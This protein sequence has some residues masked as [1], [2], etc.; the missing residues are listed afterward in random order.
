MRKKWEIISAV[1]I[2][3]IV[4]GSYIYY[5]SLFHPGDLVYRKSD[6]AVGTI[7]GIKVFDSVYLVKFDKVYSEESFSNIGPISDYKLIFNGSNINND[8]ENLENYFPGYASGFTS[9][10]VIGES[11]VK[12][13]S[14]QN[15]LNNLI[16]VNGKS[17]MVNYV[18]SAWSNCKLDLGLTGIINGSSSGGVRYKICSDKNKCL[19]NIVLSELCSFEENVTVTIKN[20]CNDTFLSIQDVENLDKTNIN[21][22]QD[23]LDLTLAFF[24]KKCSYCTDGIRDFDETGVDCGGSCTACKL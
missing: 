24:E 17:C 4:L 1:A 12:L 9:P 19:P 18:C 23:K 5:V 13:E 8:K 10:K 6:N 7:T 11:S 2:M 16:L 21:L 3:L 20:F 15:F 14:D 22:G